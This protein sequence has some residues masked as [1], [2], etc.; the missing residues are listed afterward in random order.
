MLAINHFFVKTQKTVIFQQINAK[1][2]GNIHLYLQNHLIKKLPPASTI[3]WFWPRNL[4]QIFVMVSLR[5]RTSTSV[6]WVI[7]SQGGVIVL[8][9]SVYIPS[10]NTA[11]EVA[12][13]ATVWAAGMFKSPLAWIPEVSLGPPL[14]PP[15][16]C[17]QGGGRHPPEFLEH[18]DLSISP[19]THTSLK[20]PAMIF[21]SEFV[22]S[23]NSASFLLWVRRIKESLVKFYNFYKHQWIFSKGDSL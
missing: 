7:V 9:G 12:Q 1:Y 6:I 16:R 3:V 19:P 21:S 13:S 11:K 18:Y 5:R 22:L 10:K 20:M 23:D 14:G 2:P 15:W 8:G 4:L 17:E